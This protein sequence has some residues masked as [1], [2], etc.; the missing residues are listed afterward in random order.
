MKPK[1][2]NLRK[3][4]PRIRQ[5]TVKGIEYF[6]VDGRPQH[7][8]RAFVTLKA[9]N[10][11]AELWA[12]ARDRFGRAGRLLQQRDASKVVEA[13]SF[14]EP[15]GA[16]IVDACKFYAEHL[17]DE[18]ARQTGK[19][20][21]EA[22]AAWV[23]TYTTPQH[24]I[25]TVREARSMANTISRGFEGKRITDLTGDLLKDFLLNFK[26]AEGQLASLQTRKNL[27]TKLS[28]FLNFCREKKWLTHDPLEFVKFTTA[29]DARDISTL[30]VGEAFKLL[31]AAD[32][33]PERDKLL[34]YVVAGL[35]LGLRPGEAEGL[36]WE[37][38]E[39]EQVEVK[40]K[41]SKK[42]GSNRYVT[43]NETAALWLSRCTRSTGPIIGN[44]PGA[45]RKAWETVR[46]DCGYKIGPEPAGGW[47][48]AVEWPQDVL[49][50]C[51]ASYWLAIHK[52][53]AELAELMGNT[54]DVIRQHYRR[55][56]PEAE[57]KKF[58]ALSPEPVRGKV[59][60]A[61]F[62]GKA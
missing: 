3:Q 12:K 7:K 13:L 42:R 60:K 40:G 4:W 31:R 15:Y 56:I 5:V 62:G 18:Q 58:W 44:S 50:H 19:P 57:A 6:Q 8:R 23:A 2:P 43:I 35:F 39:A 49:R 36:Q 47:G 24:R 51:Y 27:R 37:Q 30:K 38:I 41:T 11:Q 45:F 34:P 54:P 20:V 14:L 59:V 52:N 25:R 22:L 9:A 48:K 32:A 46:R 1:T 33:S 26:T 28:Q 21:A 29:E 10:S 17:A 53:R 55:A 61:Q 16:S